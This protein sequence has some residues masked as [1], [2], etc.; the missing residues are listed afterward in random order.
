MQSLRGPLGYQGS[1]TPSL[2]ARFYN[3][4]D[5]VRRHALCFRFELWWLELGSFGHGL[6]AH[7]RFQR[8]QLGFDFFV[9]L[10]LADD[11]F[12]VAPQEII[13]GFDANSDGAGGL[14]LVQILEAEVRRAR[15]LDDALNYAIDRGVVAA[16]ETRDFECHQVGMA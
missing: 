11:L 2:V 4:N 6:P 7:L 3:P 9:G 14:V 10:A 1:P 16:L 13:D 12:A 15:L 8:G 5:S